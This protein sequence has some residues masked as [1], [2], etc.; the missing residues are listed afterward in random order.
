MPLHRSPLVAIGLTAVALSCPAAENATAT[1]AAD[2]RF[3]VKHMDPSVPP[4][5]D[6]ARFAA[7]GWY[8][9]TQIPSDKSRWGGMDELAERNWENEVEP[10]SG[11]NAGSKT[12]G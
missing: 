8:G 4:G 5:Q 12:R 3:S 6:F 7:G 9:R 11:K 1:S 10:P 2:P